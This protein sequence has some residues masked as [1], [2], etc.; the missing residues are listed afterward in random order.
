MARACTVTH[1]C[2]ARD[3]SVG[4]YVHI[5]RSAALKCTVYNYD[6]GKMGDLTRKM[7]GGLKERCLTSL[8]GMRTAFV[9]VT[10]F[11]KSKALQFYSIP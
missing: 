5:K 1:T 4:R 6:Q 8:V 11:D 10:P 9:P 2:L 7:K 3:L